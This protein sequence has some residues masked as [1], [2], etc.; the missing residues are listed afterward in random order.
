MIPDHEVFLTGS[1]RSH[2]GGKIA[3]R[4]LAASL[5]A[6]DP[7]RIINRSISRSGS[8]LQ[9]KSHTI[10]LDEYKRIFILAAGK[11]ALPMGSALEELLGPFLTGSFY[12]SKTGHQEW[13][14]IRGE[15]YLG[16]HPI[17]DQDSISGTDAILNLQKIKVSPRVI[18]LDFV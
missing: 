5:M 18:E 2:Q 1:L 4:I 12:I 10:N 13:T 16:G 6:V 15:V 11:A 7:A 8:L 17:P 3:A 14:D 9:V